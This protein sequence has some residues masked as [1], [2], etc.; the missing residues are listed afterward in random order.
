MAEQGWLSD[1]MDPLARWLGSVPLFSG[2]DETSREALAAEFET[3][4]VTAGSTIIEQG[5]I[6]TSLYL[7]TSGRLRV[8]ARTQGDER[9]L[10]ELAPPSIVGEMALLSESERTATVHAVRDCE[11]LRLHRGVFSR[12]VELHPSVLT[13]VSRLLVE[14]LV[15]SAQSHAPHYSRAPSS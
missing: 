8:S 12:L 15:A 4:H 2:L 1:T 9:V 6:E 5:Q 7:L 11:V 14:R 3:E 10:Y 13:Q